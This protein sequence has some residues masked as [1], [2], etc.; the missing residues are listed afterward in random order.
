[1]AV[2]AFASLTL[3]ALLAVHGARAH[4]MEI[5]DGAEQDQHVAQVD[6][7]LAGELP[8]DPIRPP[9]YPLLAAAVASLGLEPFAAARAVSNGA[10]AALAALAWGIARRLGGPV[11]GW[12]AFALVAAHPFVWTGGQEATTDP[13]F[14]ALGALSWLC[15]LEWLARP[16]R[17]MA[18]A[19]GAALG[20]AWLTRGSAI[21]LLPGFLLL[22]LFARRAGGE[23]RGRRR[24]DLVAAA[25]ACVAVGLPLLA[26][27]W[28]QFGDPF[29]DENWRSLAFKLYGEGDWSYLERAPFGGV[30]GVVAADPGRFVVGGLEQLLVLLRSGARMLFGHVAVALSAVAGLALARRRSSALWLAT[31]A[32]T[33]GIA[34]AFAFYSWHRFLS[35]LLPV[36][37]AFVAV[38]LGE[39]GRELLARIAPRA[40]ARWPRAPAAAG[41]A[42]TLCVLGAFAGRT[43]RE[44]IPRFVA[45]HPI[46]EARLLRELAGSLPPGS[47]IAGTRSF[48]ARQVPGNRYVALP[49]P[50]G[51]ELERPELYLER[52]RALFERE[53]IGWLVAGAV[54]LG[55]R[56][57][58]LLDERPPAEWLRAEH[59][60]G[61][62]R[63]WRVV[64][65]RDRPPDG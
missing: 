20:L 25:L 7:F 36:A 14:A 13:L 30:L 45:A 17:R 16:E 32:L 24:H 61:S 65:L 54:G 5:V 4:P 11:S 52:M 47:G 3:F 18:V 19:W 8:R 38:S 39:P 34:L 35:I 10:S 56:P 33:Y 58:A 53:R 63:L 64:G 41:A 44:A 21:F 50:L 37:L 46:A 42:A 22:P 57:R 12:I 27:R 60:D 29:H 15:A 31:A 48:L 55:G 43:T 49:E 40:L 23:E 6:R 1:M 62:A 51:E 59:G 2:L 28:D 9:L 26:L